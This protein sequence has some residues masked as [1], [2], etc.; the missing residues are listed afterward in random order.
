MPQCFMNSRS[1]CVS[2]LKVKVAG[3]SQHDTI[4]TSFLE[5]FAIYNDVGVKYVECPKI[6]PVYS[7]YHRIATRA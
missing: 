2:A 4:R 7:S 3:E 1:I 5:H 6:R